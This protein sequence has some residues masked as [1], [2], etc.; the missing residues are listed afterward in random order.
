MV[1]ALGVSL[2]YRGLGRAPIGVRSPVGSRGRFLLGDAG[3][4][5]RFKSSI[6]AVKINDFA[7]FSNVCMPPL[8]KQTWQSVHSDKAP[9]A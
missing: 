8:R 5:L 6:S 3:N 4:N 7:I 9:G 2:Y 1:S